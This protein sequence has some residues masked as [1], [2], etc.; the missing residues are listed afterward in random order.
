MT[1]D[2]VREPLLSV[3]DVA[4][5]LG[6][7]PGALY[8]LRHTGRGPLGYKVGKQLRF[9]S[10]EIDRWLEIGFSAFRRDF[11]LRDVPAGTYTLDLLVGGETVAT[12]EGIEVAPGE[13]TGGVMFRESGS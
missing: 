3:R 1:H 10:S 2:E 5:Y 13:K 8:N 6:I 9:R 4:E 11:T 12:V 7:T